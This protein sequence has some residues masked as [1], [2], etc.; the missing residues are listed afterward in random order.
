[1]TPWLAEPSN[2]TVVSMLRIALLRS[3]RGWRLAACTLGL[4]LHQVS[5][6][7]VPILIGVVI[8][9]AVVRHDAIALVLWL[10]VLAVVFVVLSVSYQRATLGMVR[11]YGHGEHDLRQLSVSRV[12]HPRGSSIHRS[13]GEVLS[14]T[15]S[16]TFRV[17][18]VA[19]SIAQQGA[20]IAALLTASIALLVISVPLGVGVLVGALMV[21][22]G[23]HVLA[24][25]L[26][27]VGMAEQGSVAA[28][29]RVA[30]DTMTGLRIVRGLGAEDEMVRRYRIASAA[31]LRGA[32][33]SARKLITYQA[34]STAVSVIYLG[35]LALA[36]AWMAT[37]G[38]I[39]VGQLVTVIALAQFLQGT[40]AHIGTFGANWAHKR[41]SARRLHTL[42]ADPFALPTGD[43]TPPAT[44]AGAAP[45]VWVTDTGVVEAIPGQLTGV[46]V[47]GAAT[48]RAISARLGLR[49]PPAPGELHVHGIDA[50]T[51]GPDAYRTVVAAPPH[52]ATIFT[53]TLRENVT[54]QDADG[55]GWDEG[56]VRAVALD[57]VIE[58]LGTADAP[59]GESGRR[60]SG[61]QRQRVLL[62]RALHDPA[63][64]IV[65][66]EPTTALD[67]LTE[68]HVA[69]GLRDLG[70]TIV[71]ITSSPLLLDACHQITDLTTAGQDASEP[72]RAAVGDPATEGAR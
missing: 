57:E 72:V 13:V 40:L 39:T 66:D 8:D 56:V 54:S 42:V 65:L 34:A 60:L 47:D 18:G 43:Q 6:A 69:E 46:R 23:M 24:R 71:V 26:E 53:G 35:T 20:T 4:V 17:A 62:A 2:V 36:A 59:I 9:Q 38:Q 52:D 32:V 70:R 28:A 30:T 33:A 16:D 1:M 3:R 48:A 29:S 21:L 7:A 51:A 63:E 22:V 25:P 14:V 58:H 27:I 61:G 11:T 31:S 64:V 67:P 68:Q 49:L 15:T 10:S 5:S 50:L 41:A 55:S 44:A 37:R 12:L 19:W 45:L